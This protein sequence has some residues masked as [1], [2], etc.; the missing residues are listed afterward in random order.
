[1]KAEDAMQYLTIVIV[2]AIIIGG[3]A[4]IYYSGIKEACIWL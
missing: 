2:L 3:L 1:M 4:W